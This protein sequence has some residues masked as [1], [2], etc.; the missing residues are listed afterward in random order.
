MTSGTAKAAALLL[1]RLGTGLLLILW[2]ALC[3]V[4]PA[5]GPGLA[6]KYYGGLLVA[7]ATLVLLAFRI[8]DRW[9]LDHRRIA[10]GTQA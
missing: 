9:S 3:L 10:R 1:L 5:A 7:A 8:E 2:G 4:S 6:N